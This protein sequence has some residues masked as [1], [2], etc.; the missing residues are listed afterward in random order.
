MKRYLILIALLTMTIVLFAKPMFQANLG[1]DMAGSIKSDASGD[2]GS[3]AKM[4][5]TPSFEALWTVM[6]NMLVG[7]GIG[8]QLNRGIDETGV[9]DKVK[10]GFL[11]IYATGKYAFMKNLPVT[12]EV[13]VNLGYDLF[14][15]TK[16]FKYDDNADLGGGIN[17]AIGV[18]ANHPKGYN[19]QIMYENFNGT[20]KI[21]DLN[22]DQKDTYSTVSI[23]LGYR[24]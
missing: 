24:F 2:N 19:L 1:F 8:Y 10:F 11:P 9:P 12:P 23:Q 6:P 17:W 21:D 7:G 4:G 14:M 16:E 18:G 3:D 20:Y 15:G 22:V 5:I 13:I